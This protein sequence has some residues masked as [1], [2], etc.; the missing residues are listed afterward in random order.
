MSRFYYLITKEE[1]SLKVIAQS[2]LMNFLLEDVTKYVKDSK[3]GNI[4]Y[5][6]S[7]GVAPK[8]DKDKYEVLYDDLPFS[9]DIYECRYISEYIYRFGYIPEYKYF[10]WCIHEFYK[11][12]F[13]K[14]I[15]VYEN[16]AKCASG[17]HEDFFSRSNHIK[18]DFNSFK[19]SFESEDRFQELDEDALYIVY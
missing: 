15:I 16:G 13:F 7:P 8:R 4:Y 2:T 18:V 11:L 5:L 3:P 17:Y 10:S 19:E 1:V 14:F 6:I 12:G 9:D